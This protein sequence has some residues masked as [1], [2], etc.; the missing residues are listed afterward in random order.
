M[1]GHIETA[2]KELAFSAPLFADC[3]GDGTIGFLAG[4]DFAMGREGKDEFG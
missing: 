2:S 1:P 4:A 3:T